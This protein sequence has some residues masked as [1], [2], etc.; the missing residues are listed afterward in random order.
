MPPLAPRQPDLKR[1]A[2]HVVSALISLYPEPR[3]ALRHESPFQLLVATILSA[4]CTDARV[5][6]VT[7]TLFAK[8]PDPASLAASDPDVLESIIHST[9][10]FRAK[11]RNLRLMAS[12]L[13]NRHGGEVPESLDALT[14][15]PGVGR[16]T[17]NVVL[18]NAFGIASGVVVDTHVKRLAFRLGLTSSQ[19]PEV[20]ERD[21]V[22][23]I[24]RREWVDFSHRLIEHG[25]KVCIARAPR[26]ESCELLKLCPRM[27]VARKST[28][29]G[30]RLSRSNDSGLS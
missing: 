28:S 15:L 17:A 12:T 27:G 20:I 19:S 1:H 18:G 7:P 10:F 30:N 24:P 11:A 2:R 6:L 21:L 5:N 9:G 13:V 14:A 23:L 16:K 3:C 26:C 4:Q 8:Y 25:R 29:T 22:S